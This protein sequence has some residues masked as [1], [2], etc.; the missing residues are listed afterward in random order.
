MAG[1][2]RI[3]GCLFG[4]GERTGNVDL[5]STIR[6]EPVQR[7]ASI[8][9]ADFSDIDDVRRCVEHCNQLPV[10]STSHPYV[11]DLVHTSFPGLHQDAIRKAFAA[12]RDGDVWDMPYLPID[13]KDL[14]RSYDAVIRVNSQSG[15]GGITYLLES[16]YGLALPRL[17]QIEFSQVV[18]AVMDGEGEGTRGCGHLAHL[19]ARVRLAD[20]TRRIAT[21]T[22]DDRSSADAQATSPSSRRAAGRRQRRA[23][24]DGQRQRPDRCVRRTASRRLGADIRGCSTITSTRSAAAPRRA[25]PPTCEVRVGDAAALLRRRHRRQ[26]RERVDEG[27]ARRLRTAPASQAAT[28][29]PHSAPAVRLRESTPGERAMTDKLIIF[30]TT[31]RDGEQSPGASMTREEKLRIARQLERLRVDVIEAG[32]PASSNGDFEAVQLDRGG[33]QG[34]DRLWRSHARSTTATSRAPPRR[35]RRRHAPASTPSS[36]P[37][38]ST[39]RRSCA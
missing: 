7:R 27:G 38:S 18:Q 8:R 36:R 4:N 37:A 20:P 6:A 31:L 29:R 25:P 9:K 19:R 30:D 24:L 22:T 13:P 2:D 14:G 21:S 33:D 26:H 1:A 39:W 16:D 34:V 11:G 32:F 28:P 35:S 15:K 12:R 5:R 17:L 10:Q 23:L 3:E